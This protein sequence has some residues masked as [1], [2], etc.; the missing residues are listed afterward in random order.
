MSERGKKHSSQFP[1][2][3]SDSFKLLLLAKQTVQNSSTLM[4]KEKSQILTLKKLEKIH[5]QIN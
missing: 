4:N 1:R 2:L 5:D 3:K